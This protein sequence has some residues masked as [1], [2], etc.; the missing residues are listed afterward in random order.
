TQQDIA[1][2]AQ[3]SQSTVSR[4]LAGDGR[5][6]PTLK[7]R[8]MDVLETQKYF[9]DSRARSLR[10]QHTQL[11]GLVLCRPEGALK[12]DPFFSLLIS[13]IT[14]T[15]GPTVYRLCIDVARDQQHQAEIYDELLRTRRVDG[16][17]VV[18]PEA[19]DPRLESLQRDRFPFVVIGNPGSAPVDSV[20]NDNVVAGRLATLHL[21]ERGCRRVSFLAGP[22]GVLVSDDRVTGYSLAMREKGLEETVVH[23]GFGARAA[24]RAAAGMLQSGRRTDGLVVLDDYMALGVAGAARSLGM[25]IPDDLAVVSFNDTSLCTVVEGGLTS[26]NL[27]VEA[28]VREAVGLLVRRIE[29]Q[30]AEPVR[31]LVSAELKVRRTSLMPAGP[32]RLC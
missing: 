17:I 29:N 11:I 6:E 14:H 24:E 4:V 16:L 19:A 7:R 10:A 30:D 25:R 3:V 28:L 21:V 23:A 22:K 31:R 12:D 20:D 1:K 2:L 18:E 8:V 13:E 27:N 32:E 15:L 26:V 9:A 5:V